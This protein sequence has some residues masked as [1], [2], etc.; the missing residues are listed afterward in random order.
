MCGEVEMEWI[1]EPDFELD[2]YV[3]AIAWMPN[4]TGLVAATAHG[5]VVMFEDFDRPKSPLAKTKIIKKKEEDGFSLDA[6]EWSADGKYLVAAGQRGELYIWNEGELIETLIYSGWIDVLAWH[7][8]RSL[9]AFGVGKTIYIWNAETKAIESSLE[10]L[11]S[12]VLALAWNTKGDRLMASGNRIVK[13]WDVQNWTANPTIWDLSAACGSIAWA[14]EDR[15]FAA[16][17]FDRTVLVALEFGSEDPWR[18]SGFPEKISLLA[19]SSVI[20]PITGCPMLATVSGDGVVIWNWNGEGWDGDIVVSEGS[21][22]NTIAWQPGKLSF[23][24]GT[25]ERIEIRTFS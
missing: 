23:A 1:R 24:I 9:L 18:M 21:R 12:S 7:P 8:G 15:F 20:N 16:G 19:W 17:C 5:E 11:K 13:C 6:L 3:T 2:E 4:G 14:P 25:K 22:I 10:Q